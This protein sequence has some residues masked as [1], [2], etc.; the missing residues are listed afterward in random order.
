MAFLSDF[1]IYINSYTKSD[2]NDENDEILMVMMIMTKM[3]MIK[4]MMNQ[5]GLPI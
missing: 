2:D 5:M 1:K 4:I 3:T